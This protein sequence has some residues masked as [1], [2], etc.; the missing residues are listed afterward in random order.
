MIVGRVAE[1]GMRS[2]FD[3]FSYR[4]AGESYK[5]SQGGPIGARVTMAAAR[6]VMQTWGEEYGEILRSSGLEVDFLNGYCYDNRQESTLLKKWMRFVEREKR[7]KITMEGLE[8]DRDIDI[9][10][11][12]NERMARLGLPAMHSINEDLKLTVEIH[13]EFPGN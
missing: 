4:F 6:L 3:N 9:K 11:N 10:I 13:E 1:I 5:Q 2:G 8:E 7:F 12:K